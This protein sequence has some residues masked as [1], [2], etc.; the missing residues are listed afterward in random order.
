MLVHTSLVSLNR[1]TEN[2][3]QHVYIIV[4]FVGIYFL[5]EAKG[6]CCS[7]VQNCRKSLKVFLEN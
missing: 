5:P 2:E 7:N 6:I 3:L 4:T 1:L